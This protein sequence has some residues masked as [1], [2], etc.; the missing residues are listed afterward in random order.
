MGSNGGADGVSRFG[1]AVALLRRNGV[2]AVAFDMDQ[3]AVSRHSRGRLRRTDLDAYLNQSV[4]DFVHLVPLLHESGIGVGIATHSDEA[5]YGRFIRPE[6]HILGSELA[7]AVLDRCFE[8]NVAS[9]CLVVAYNPR[10]RGPE[11][12]LQENRVKRFHVRQ[13][14]RHYGA[15]PNQILLVDDLDEVVDDCRSH[16]GIHAVKVNPAT[17]FCLQD[18]LEYDFQLHEQAQSGR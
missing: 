18:L 12:A 11:G 6:T 15:E 13:F 17:G 4:P 8:P 9:R 7:R 16:C 14:L 5:Q 2:R 10:A 1:E 3:T